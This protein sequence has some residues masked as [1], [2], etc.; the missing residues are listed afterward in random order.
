M[1]QPL[2]NHVVDLERRIADLERQLADMRSERQYWN[3]KAED[4]A[5]LVEQLARQLAEAEGKTT[6]A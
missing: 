6:D 4:Q 1:T 2:T 5:A 3:S